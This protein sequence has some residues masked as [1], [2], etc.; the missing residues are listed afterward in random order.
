MVSCVVSFIVGFIFG[1]GVA[2]VIA[3]NV[4]GCRQR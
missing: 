4:Y 1:M 3:V 2:F